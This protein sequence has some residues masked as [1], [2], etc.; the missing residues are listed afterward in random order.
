MH[1]ILGYASQNEA[2]NMLIKPKIASE[3]FQDH[4]SWKYFGEDW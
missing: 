3:H 1:E 4:I 2:G